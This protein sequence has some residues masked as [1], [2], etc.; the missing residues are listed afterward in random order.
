MRY[1]SNLAVATFAALLLVLSNSA[2]A[3]SKRVA[4]VIGNSNYE[5]VS[6]LENPRNDSTDVAAALERLGFDVMLFHDLNYDK[7]RRNLREFSRRAQG[8]ERALV[9][10]AGHG[11]EV[12]GTNYL[13][14]VDAQLR[15]D[16]D[17]EFEAIPL[18][19]G[20]SA[21]EGAGELRMLL[22]DACRNNPFLTKIKKTSSTRSIGRGLARVEPAVGT[23]V[24]FAAKEGTTADDGEGRNSPYTAALLENLE[25]PGL[26]LNFLFRKVRDKV[27]Q[28]TRG[29][30]QPFTYGSLPG[31]KIFLKS[32]TDNALA[33]ATMTPQNPVPNLPARNSQDSLLA[34]EMLYW[35]T[36]KDSADAALLNS[37]LEEYPDGKFSTIARLM[38]ARIKPEQP[39]AAVQPAQAEP[40]ADEEENTRV[41]AIPPQTPVT[42][43]ASIAEVQSK[44]YQLNYDPGPAD[45]AI[46]ARTVAALNAFQSDNGLAGDSR[47]TVGLVDRIRAQSVP[48]Q[49]GVIGFWPARKKISV[50]ANLGSR[51]AAETTLRS[52]CSNCSQSLTFAGGD[53]AAIALSSRGWGWAVRSDLQA[54]R[55]KAL[56]I[57]GRHGG[58]CVVKSD[59]CAASN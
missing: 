32:P 33:A 20:M 37:Y 31:K 30:Q 45:G 2:W 39:R 56:E 4:L 40:P 47:L 25:E 35:N 51:K 8:S 12:N 15:N 24:S 17:V 27:Y 29:R 18:D 53:C 54:A 9:Y 19:S 48:S 41:A 7:M 43:R 44:L 36:V 49:W 10:F 23:L 21:V 16:L 57:C 11:I 52:K 28:T 34:A 59:A 3:A 58:G 6:Q 1:W 5:A 55:A 38:I 14:P 22:L 50:S 13:I 46:G 26:E 42:D